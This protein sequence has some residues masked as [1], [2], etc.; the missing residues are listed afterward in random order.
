MMQRALLLLGML[1]AMAIAQATSLPP[2]VDAATRAALETIVDSARAS[3]L[4][5]E[6]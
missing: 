1:P 5:L 6:P 3:G 2:G 4:P